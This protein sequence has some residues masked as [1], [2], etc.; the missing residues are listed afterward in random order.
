MGMDVIGN[1]P[2]S[3][4]GEYFRNN[5]WWWRP[6]WDYCCEVSEE[7]RSVKYG[8]SND[9]DGLDAEKAKALAKILI[10]EIGL[11]NTKK[12]EQQ[13][14]KELSELPLDDCDLCE[15]TGI[16]KTGALDKDVE[17]FINYELRP[18]QQALYGRTTGWCNAC[19]GAGH[20]P[21]WASNYPFSVE[22]VA[23]FAEFLL[24]CGGFA[25]C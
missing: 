11:G 16:R 25:I 22:N 7:A 19:D 2:K 1:N 6:L 8:H 12:Y 14:R 5:V 21:N 4:T 9:G 10:N 13:Y 20:K 24:D 18:E 23:E 17:Y 15:N 3:Q